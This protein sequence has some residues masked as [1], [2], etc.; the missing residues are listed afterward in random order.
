MDTNAIENRFIA[1]RSSTLFSINT[2]TKSETKQILNV[3]PNFQQ[4]YHRKSSNIS[5]RKRFILN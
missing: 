2:M 4:S 1:V 5:K 3:G